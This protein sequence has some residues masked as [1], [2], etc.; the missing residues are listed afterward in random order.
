MSARPVLPPRE[1]QKFAELQ[2]AVE[3]QILKSFPSPSSSVSFHKEPSKHFFVY[4]KGQPA[5]RLDVELADD[6][7]S[8]QFQ[9][10]EATRASFSLR[11]LADGEIHLFNGE[12]RITIE[13][14]VDLLLAS[15]L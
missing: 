13:Q 7:K 2:E 6:L 9:T 15:F 1:H 11:K 4:Q 10:S 5:L 8:I 14:A 3:E 12:Q